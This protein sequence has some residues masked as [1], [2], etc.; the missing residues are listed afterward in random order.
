MLRVPLRRF[1]SDSCSATSSQQPGVALWDAAFR[2]SRW[3]T[4]GWTL[5]ELIAPQIVEFYSKE[6]VFLGDKRSLEAA[7]RDVT[8]VPAKA[9]RGTPL[10]DFTT[11][12]REAWARNQKT[13]YE[14]DMAYSLLGIFG[15][16]MPLIYGEG[17]ENAQKRLREEVQ[18]S[19]KGKIQLS[20][21]GFILTNA[22]RRSPQLFNQL[23]SFW[24]S[25]DST[26]CGKRC[27]SSR[28][29]EDAVLG[30]EPS[31][32]RTPRSRRHRQDTARCDL[33][34]SISG[35]VLGHLL[36]QCQGR[37]IHSAELC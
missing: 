30:W 17:R 23:Q 34:Q 26:F 36:A 16:H 4:R 28:D 9:L 35:R 37:S 27:R 21:R 5:Q 33:Y 19:V 31:H 1:L 6:G 15:V 24:H 22:L 14:E 10:S 11:S 25:R 7:V 20:E 32:C 29:A 3:F 2:G 18:K 8:G 12:E 13:K